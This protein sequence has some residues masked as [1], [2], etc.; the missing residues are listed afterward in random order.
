MTLIVGN[1]SNYKNTT[2][3]LVYNVAWTISQ[4]TGS[5]IIIAAIKKAPTDGTFMAFPAIRTLD[6]SEAL[7]VDSLGAPQLLAC[8]PF[9]GT[10]WLESNSS[11]DMNLLSTF[12]V[13]LLN[14]LN[15]CL[16]FS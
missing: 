5:N 14:T 6:L 15:K 3:R 12:R 16:N 11:G 9:T 7:V 4:A 1:L 8:L 13:D 2:R 10:T